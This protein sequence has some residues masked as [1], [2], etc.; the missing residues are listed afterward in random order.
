SVDLGAASSEPALSRC[1]LILVAAPRDRVSP[2][3]AQRLLNAARRGQALLVSIGPTRG[4]DQRPAPSGLEP[5]LEQFGLRV[6]P[7][8]IFERDPD[9]VLPVGLGGEAFLA[10]PRSHAITQGLVQGD[11]VRYRVLLQLAQGL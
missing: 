5:L 7:G 10:A 1:D 6:K 4:D 2:S 3:A 11:A 9:A 8:L